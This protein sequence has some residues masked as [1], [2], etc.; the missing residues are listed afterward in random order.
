MRFTL[1]VCLCSLSS[2]QYLEISPSAASVLPGQ[3]VQFTATIGGIATPAA[4][5]NFSWRISGAQIGTIDQTGLYTAPPAPATQSVTVMVTANV[6]PP[7]GAIPQLLG[8]F[9]KVNIFNGGS[10]V[11]Q[12]GPKGDTGPPGPAGP[13]GP[14][15]PQGPSGSSSGIA[16]ASHWQYQE[17]PSGGYSPGMKP[18]GTGYILT[19]ACQPIPQTIHIWFGGL[20]Y[21]SGL[22]F[23]TGPTD[24]LGGSS[25]LG[26][27]QIA[28]LNFDQG[29]ARPPGD[30]NYSCGNGPCPVFRVD[31]QYVPDSTAKCP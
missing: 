8:A 26:S 7:A 10:G 9:A 1:A 22:R 27:K 11:G 3:S 18:Y 17:I 23:Y 6:Q 2:A 13:Q 29:F 19:L 5:T 20:L 24:P 25:G 31:Y 14:M 12:P 28:A 21:Y 16:S 4:V 15:G 30:P